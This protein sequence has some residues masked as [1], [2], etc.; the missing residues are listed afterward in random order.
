MTPEQIR[1]AIAASEDLRALVPDSGAIAAALSVGRSV[2]NTATKYTSLGIAER[3]PSLGGLPGPL[4][5]ELCLQKLEG[6][7]A[8]AMASTAPATKLLGAATARQMG[9]LAG[10]GMAVGSP[11]VG[12]MLAVIVQ[13][14]ALTQAEA[15]ALQDVAREPAPITEY[16]VRVA[17]YADDGSLKV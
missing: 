10:A 9:H 6:F 15:D 16:A 4:A 7:A 1:A 13:A 3:Y 17:I 2:R 12:D 8:A 14:G 11:A 5:A